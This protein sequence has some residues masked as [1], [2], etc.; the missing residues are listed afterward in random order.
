M[1]ERKFVE[2][3]DENGASVKFEIVVDFE[4]DGQEYA[5]LVEEGEEEAVLFRVI[6]DGEEEPS[7]EVVTD[8][9]EFDNV[10]RVYEELMDQED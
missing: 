3:I 10:A 4:V 7:F 6:D 9:A 8:D 1:E 5:V 2:L